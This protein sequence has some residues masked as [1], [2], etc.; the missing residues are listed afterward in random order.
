MKINFIKNISFNYLIYL[1]IIVV[2]LISVP[3]FLNTLGHEKFGVWQILSSISLLFTLY[4]G[5]REILL[6]NTVTSLLASNRKRYIKLYFTDTIKILAKNYSIILFIVIALKIV[7]LIFDFDFNNIYLD[8]Y[9]NIFLFFISFSFINSF[10]T[11]L[12]NISN[13]SIN[14]YLASLSNLLSQ[15]FLL[16]FVILLPDFLFNDLYIFISI[17]F[18]TLLISTF[19]IF[20][21]LK[22]KYELQFFFKRRIEYKTQKKESSSFLK[23]QVLSIIFLSLDY[24]FIIRNFSPNIAG[25]YSIL[26]KPFISI[27]SFFSIILVHFWSYISL[28]YSTN[29]TLMLNKSLKII[30]YLNLILL[31]ITVFFSFYST[32]ILKIWLG[33][34]FFVFDKSIL[35]LFSIHTA[36]HCFNAIFLTI[37]NAINRVFENMKSLFLANILYIIIIIFFNHQIYSIN[38]LLYIK[39]F[40]SLISILFNIKILNKLNVNFTSL[41][42]YKR[43]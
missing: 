35:F 27:I 22:K 32:F 11:I 15:T 34:D 29:N 9:R 16:F 4:S 2:N 25:E 28:F 18:L 20:Y 7:D 17:Y 24:I 36:L 42:C 14:P 12:N 26:S 30:I 5:G 1:L 21:I 6:R 40:F 31:V 37:Q 39:I 19:L 10:Y 13:G 33:K 43:I 38:H 8:K 41:F 23:L 3:I